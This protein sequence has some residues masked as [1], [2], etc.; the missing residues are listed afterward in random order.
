LSDFG[1]N[2]FEEL[3]NYSGLMTRRKMVIQIGKKIY[4][5]FEKAC[6]GRNPGWMPASVQSK[7]KL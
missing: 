6:P 5:V 4:G 7:P 3:N 2:R 1:I